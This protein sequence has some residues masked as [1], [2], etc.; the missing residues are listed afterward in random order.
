MP[1]GTI[2]A[3]GEA[4]DDENGINMENT[5]HNLKW[6]AVRGDIHDW[7]IYCYWVENSIE[8]IRGRGDKVHNESTIKKL[9]PC[10][11]EALKMYRH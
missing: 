9:V 1:E 7:T 5:G 4:L 2:F 10:D 11:D 3:T 6:I 8:Y